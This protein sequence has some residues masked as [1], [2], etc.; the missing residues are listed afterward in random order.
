MTRFVGAAALAFGMFACNGESNLVGNA[1]PNY[2]HA[3][4]YTLEEGQTYVKNP[5]V[6]LRREYWIVVRA[7]DGKHFMLPRPDGDPRIVQE[8]TTNGPLAEMFANADLCVSA[9]AA[10]IFRVNGLT[11]SEAMQTSTFLHG[12]LKFVVVGGGGEPGGARVE[13]F[14]H[15]DDLLDICKTF[16]DDRNGTL[17]GVC[18]EELRYE[19]GGERPAIA[20]S[21]T[22]DECN[23]MAKRLNEIY[24]I[25]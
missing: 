13:P 7:K 23:V 9:T 15:T 16:P 2:P 22:A 25:L 21:Y 19:N 8:C 20:R 18:D 17:K 10:T 4:E 5:D 6:K 11:A 24:G 12:K 3:R 14:P 1:P